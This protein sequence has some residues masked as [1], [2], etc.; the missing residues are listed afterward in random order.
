MPYRVLPSLE[1][2]ARLKFH[3]GWSGWTR[4]PQ[5]GG[6]GGGWLNALRLDASANFKPYASKATTAIPVPKAE[7]P[8]TRSFLSGFVSAIL[9]LSL[10]FGLIKVEGCAKNVL[11]RTAWR[12]LA[13]LVTYSGSS[14]YLC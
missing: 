5:H 4:P 7:Q 12:R 9:F 6:G 10:P 11:A 2:W 1:P 14:T 8:V 3:A 13:A